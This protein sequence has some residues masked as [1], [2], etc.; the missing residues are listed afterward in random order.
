MKLSYDSSKVIA[1]RLGKDKGGI[2]K[3][4]VWRMI[5]GILLGHRREQEANDFRGQSC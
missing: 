2:Y 3:S 5:Q 1:R 4:Y